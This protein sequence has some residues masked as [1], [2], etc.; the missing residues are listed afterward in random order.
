MDK[1]DIHKLIE[2]YFDATLSAHDETLLVHM[3]S[4]TDEDTEDIREAKATMGLFAM[5]RKLT[6]KK[7]RGGKSKSV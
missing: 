4:Q 6:G 1:R 2:E 3:L 5:N 7:L